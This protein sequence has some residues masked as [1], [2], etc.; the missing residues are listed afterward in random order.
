MGQHRIERV[1]AQIS[2]VNPFSF[3]GK[4]DTGASALLLDERGYDLRAAA[5]CVRKESARLALR[6][7]A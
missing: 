1:A 7:E 4:S 6:F 5:F 2:D 3:A